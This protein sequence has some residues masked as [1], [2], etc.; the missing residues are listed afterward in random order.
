MNLTHIIEHY[1]EA[2]LNKYNLSHDQRH[3]L[4]ATLHCHT[5][6]YGSIELHCSSC[7]HDQIQHPSCG[8]RSCHRCQ[9]HLTTQWI[10]RQSQKLLPVE[11]F[12][13]TFTLPFELRSVARHNQ[14]GFYTLLFECAISTL[15]TFG[16]NHKKLAA[17]L[18]MTAVLHTHSRALNYHP[19]IHII[20]PGGALD[21]KH[22]LWKKHHGEFLFKGESLAKVFRGRLLQALN[23]AS[24]PIPMNM[25]KQWVVDCRHVGQ[26]LP[27]LRYLS[28][29]LY[30]GVIAEKNIIADDGESVTFRYTDNNGDTQY[31][32]LKGED[33]LWLIFQHVL[34]KGFRRIR[35]YGFLHPNAKSTLRLIQQILR[36]FLPELIPQK[37]PDYLCRHC[38][39]PMRITAF[40]KPRWRSG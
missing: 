23:D 32:T 3:A 5:P 29:Y 28:R 37:R 7:E 38:R 6:R 25:P 16:L 17:E 11:Y 31:R 2:F 14:K 9:N 24:L 36:V 30:R 4:D 13:V 10:E 1:K 20:V 18:A 21:R 12:M 40:I 22:R 8:H 19:H 39:A 26:G 27:A 34:P 35:D 15:K 33:F